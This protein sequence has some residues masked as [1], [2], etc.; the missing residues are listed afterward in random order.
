MILA[1][2]V[3]K[4]NSGSAMYELCFGNDIQHILFNLPSNH[5]RDSIHWRILAEV[6]FC[7]ESFVAIAQGEGDLGNHR[8]LFCVLYNYP[9]KVTTY[10]KI[11]DMLNN[12][13]T[14]PIS[15]RILELN[16]AVV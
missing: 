9:L 10:Q 3:W 2:L 4:L 5:V 1:E 13:A 16:N 11:A 15:R 14:E 12:K 8:S 7:A 6:D